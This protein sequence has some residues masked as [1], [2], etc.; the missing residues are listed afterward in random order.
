MGR[1]CRLD[2]EFCETNLEDYINGVGSGFG[3]MSWADARSQGKDI[4]LIVAIF[5]QLLSGVSFIHSHDQIHGFLSP[6]KSN[7][8]LITS[9]TKKLY[10]PQK[11]GGGKLRNLERRTK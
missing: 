7:S 11:V 2:S 6:D 4:F 8:F 3:L 5:Q 1:W 10:I 9:L